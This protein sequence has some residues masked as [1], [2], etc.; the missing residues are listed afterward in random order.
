MI[1]ATI[2][3]GDNFTVLDAKGMLD[4]MNAM[5]ATIAERDATIER[6]R[7]ALLRISFVE[8]GLNPSYQ[9]TLASAALS[10]DTPPEAA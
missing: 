7:E 5:R 8:P 10:D 1:D 3:D 9:Q 2:K 6:L 4:R